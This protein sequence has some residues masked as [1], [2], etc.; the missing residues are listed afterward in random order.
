MKKDIIVMGSSRAIHHYNPAMIVDSL[1]LSCYNCGQDGNGIVF[2]YGQWLLIKERYQPKFI[3]YDV[4]PKYDCLQGDNHR[5][6]GWLKLYY[7]REGISDIFQEVDETE[8]IKMLSLM[9]KY[10]YNPLQLIADYIKPIYKVDSMGFA[11]IKGKLDPMRI[12][13]SKD[14]KVYQYDSLKIRFIED[15][16][17]NRGNAEIV[18]VVSPIWYGMEEAS[19][20]PIKHLC[21]KYGCKFIDFSNSKKYFHKN[22]YF[23]DG[24]HMNEKG[25]NEFTKDLLVILC[26][27]R[28]KDV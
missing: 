10:N 25:A 23:K 12:K 17:T 27:M 7:E 19:F 21:S 11:P 8:K 20:E 4:N 3:I 5:Y 16:I 2:N 9:Y 6:L 14:N 15:L 26:D 13:K 18:F 22:A 1:G 28:K 24:N